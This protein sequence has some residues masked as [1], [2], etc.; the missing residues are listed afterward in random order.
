MVMEDFFTC[1]PAAHFI[2]KNNVIVLYKTGMVV[3]V[4][5]S[6]NVVYFEMLICQKLFA[7]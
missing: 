6:R 5:N 1:P 4:F 3:S 7:S 2:M